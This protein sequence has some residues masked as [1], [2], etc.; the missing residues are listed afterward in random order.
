VDAKEHTNGTSKS[1]NG[2][3]NSNTDNMT[4][5]QNGSVAKN[6]S[7]ANGEAGIDEGLYSRQLYVLGH[8]V[9]IL[10]IS[11]SSKQ[12]RANLYYLVVDKILSDNKR[13]T[14]Q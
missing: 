13:Q 2:S 9:S 5:T 10:C 3:R 14:T 1:S 12:F 8:Q 6:G 4:S 7:E 11:I